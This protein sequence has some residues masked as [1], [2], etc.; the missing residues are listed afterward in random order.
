MI[1]FTPST[2]LHSAGTLEP[3]TWSRGFTASATAMAQEFISSRS[4]QPIKAVILGPPGGRQSHVC[5]QARSTLEYPII[6]NVSH[7]P[8]EARCLLLSNKII[9]C[10]YYLIHKH[11]A[12]STCAHNAPQAYCKQTLRLV[13]LRENCALQISQRYGLMRVDAKVAV[14]GVFEALGKPLPL[15]VSAEEK[16]PPPAKGKKAKD[17]KKG[18]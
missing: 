13:A 5:K 18:R 11:T 8:K 12:M 17:T 6:R 2:P 14:D 1:P 10:V 3:V 15:P 7:K 16:A 4:L 9:L